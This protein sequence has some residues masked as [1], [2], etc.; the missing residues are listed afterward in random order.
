MNNEIHLPTVSGAIDVISVPIS[1]TATVKKYS[2]FL[3]QFGGVPPVPSIV[4]DTLTDGVTP[5]VFAIVGVGEYTATYVGAFANPFFAVIGNGLV[6]SDVQIFRVEKL[7]DDT[8]LIR[9]L[10]RTIVPIDDWEGYLDIRT[11]VNTG[12]SEEVFNYLLSQLDAVQQSLWTKI[13]LRTVGNVVTEVD[14]K[15]YRRPI[16]T[17][18][19]S[20][21]I[22]NS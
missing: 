15:K 8:I 17:F 2:A 1:E 21:K 14:G 22:I 7:D 5:L 10:D 19:N 4:E 16:G 20:S 18:A 12:T 3:T 11:K 9:S 6:L 13:V